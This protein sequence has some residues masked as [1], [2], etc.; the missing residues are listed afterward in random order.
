MKSENS[1]AQIKCTSYSHI[2]FSQS[3]RV[4]ITNLDFIGCGGNL[5]EEVEEFVVRDSKFEGQQSSGIA[6]ELIETIAQI[7]NSTFA[8]RRAIIATNSSIDINQSVFENNR[9]GIGGAILAEQNSVINLSGN[10]FINN[11]AYFL[12]GVLRSDSSTITIEANNNSADYGGVLHSGSSTI[13]IEASE[14]NNNS[15]E[16]GG[17]LHSSSS[18]ITIGGSN[19]TK[20]VSPIGAVIYATDRSK[21]QHNHKHLLIDNNMADRYAVIYLFDSEFIGHDS[22]N[23]ITF[24]NNLGS[25]VA[26]NSN[27]TLNGHDLFVNNQPPQ[28]ASGD[29][30]K[31]GA[32]TLRQSNAFFYGACNLEHNH[33]ENGGAI[34][35][36]ESKL[37]VNGYV[38]IA[39]N[40]ATG[41]GGGV[42]LS[43][44]E[45]NCQHKSTFELFNNTAEYKGGGDSIPLAHLSRQLHPFHGDT[46]VQE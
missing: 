16:C 7:V 28:T 38:T 30:Q 26:F 44:S 34:H 33:A 14:F 42:Y 12:G 5:V 43:T 40:T 18:T 36:T 20:N 45:L 1:T 23:V 13:T 35:S 22:E 32:I 25:L 24:S 29:F 3:Q 21:I 8:N 41:N 15:A 9:A 27:I 19:F 2:Q 6:L 39:H 4:H 11:S 17:V 31:G 37:Y 10:V 46:L